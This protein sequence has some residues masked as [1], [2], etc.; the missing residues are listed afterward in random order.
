MLKNSM[1]KLWHNQMV[2][3]Y[4][5]IKNIFRRTFNNIGKCSHY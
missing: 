5:T 1:I 2:E 3:Y 4:V